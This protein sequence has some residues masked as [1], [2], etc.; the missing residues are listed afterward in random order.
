MSKIERNP[1]RRAPHAPLVCTRLVRAALAR[2]YACMRAT[3]GPRDIG[4]GRPVQ[5][6]VQLILIKMAGRAAGVDI[7]I[8]FPRRRPPPSEGEREQGGGSI[9]AR[10]RG[11]FDAS[12]AFRVPIENCLASRVIRVASDA[13]QRRSVNREKA[14]NLRNDGISKASRFVR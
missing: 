12:L 3:R 11:N 6:G 2:N 1:A 14:R 13:K 9:R 5:S 10:E 8:P 4:P 7:I